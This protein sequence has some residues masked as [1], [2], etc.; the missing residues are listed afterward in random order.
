MLDG[1]AVV[2]TRPLVNRI[3][4]LEPGT[5][6][7]VD[8]DCAKGHRAYARSRQAFDEAPGLEIDE[9]APYENDPEEH[10]REGE[11]RHE[12]K[13]RIGIHRTVKSSRPHRPRPRPPAP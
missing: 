13:Q 7:A 3:G 6:N 5:D 11:E 2:N 9:A 8:F 1:Q 4:H 12:R 10:A